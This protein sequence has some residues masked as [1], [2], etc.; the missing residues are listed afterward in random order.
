MPTTRF[1]T[2][3][4]L[5]LLARRL[6]FLGYDV[7]TVRGARLEELFEYGGREGRMVLTSSGRHPRRW[8]AVPALRVERERPEEA[9]RTIAAGHEP[10][11]APFSRCASCGSAL[12]RRH[13]LEAQGEV[14]GRVIRSNRELRYCAACAKWYWEGSHVARIRAWLEAVL[15][16]PLAGEGPPAAG[17]TG[18]AP[19]PPGTP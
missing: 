4:S 10:A 15:G 18:G 13:P 16:R 3:S 17:A 6:R 8:A 9:V 19:A 1:V 2:D 7:V 14:P 12:Q 11:G 5:D